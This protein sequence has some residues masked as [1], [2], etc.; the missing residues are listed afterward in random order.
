MWTIVP[1]V[2][3][4]VVTPSVKIVFCRSMSQELA[5]D[6]IILFILYMNNCKSDPDLEPVAME[7]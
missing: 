2:G 3:H 6:D 1:W 4:S 5:P 7:I